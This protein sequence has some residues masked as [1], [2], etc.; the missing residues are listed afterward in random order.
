MLPGNNRDELNYGGKII[1]PP[2]SLNKLTR[3]HIQYP[4]LFKLHS[5]E[6]GMTTHCGVLEFIAPEGQVYIPQWMMETLAISPGSLIKV[7]NTSLSLGTFVK[8]EPQSVDFLEISDPKAVLE[9]ALRNY[10]TLTKDDVF[11]ISYNDKIYSIKVIE[12]KPDLEE[13]NHGISV[14]ETD[15][16]VDF[17]PPVGYVD[18]ASVSDSRPGSVI[19]SGMVSRTGTPKSAG[20]GSATPA[21]SPLGGMAKSINYEDILRRELVKKTAN[22]FQGSG[23]KLSASSGRTLGS[24]TTSSS[25]SVDR[26]GKSVSSKKKALEKGRE[27][28]K[29]REQEEEINNRILTELPDVNAGPL[30]LPF[31]HLFFGYPIVPVK[32]IEDEM[33]LEKENAVNEVKFEGS[34]KSLRKS[35]KR[36]DKT[37]HSTTSPVKRSTPSPREVIEID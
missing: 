3:L 35:K 5:E 27:M 18:P 11:Q 20:S 23:H 15:L 25:L 22:G 7:T 32:H 10:S 8:I 16:E 19:S 28:E 24:T 1:M 21:P 29:Q 6:T 34:G 33:E 26:K 12:V 14:V 30:N 4:M 9:N 17:A 2:S 31:G 36:K 13:N 37:T